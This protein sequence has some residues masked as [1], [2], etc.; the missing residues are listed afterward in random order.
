MTDPSNMA[1]QK[2]VT[3][4]LVE[5]TNGPASSEAYILNPGDRGLFGS[6]EGLSAEGASARAPGGGPSIAAHVDHLCYGLEL[7]N[8]WRRGEKNPFA[9]ADYAASWQRLAVSEPEW[10]QL[11]DR[12]RHEVAAWR[13]VMVEPLEPHDMTLKGVLS[14]VIHLAYHVGAIRQIHRSAGGPKAQD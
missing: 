9:T 11:R 10:R 7:L 3:D 4:L 2:A 12:L 14:S 1:W 6:L 13:T 8:R 5:L